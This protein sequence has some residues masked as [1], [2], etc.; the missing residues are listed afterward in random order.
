MVECDITLR[1]WGN[2]LGATLPK[3]IIE[4]AG[5][6]ENETVK[7]LILKKNKTANKLF[8]MLQGKRRMSGQEAKDLIRKELHNIE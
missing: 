5:L 8:G 2:S 3:E 6:H 7:V 4:E 1:K